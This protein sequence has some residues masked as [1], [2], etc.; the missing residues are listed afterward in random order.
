MGLRRFDGRVDGAAV[1]SWA[2]SR[3]RLVALD[4][5]RG[6][7]STPKQAAILS[8]DG[9]SQQALKRMLDTVRAQASRIG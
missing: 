4:T 9:Q 8:R 2:W 6:S 3:M 5:R 7:L 1:T